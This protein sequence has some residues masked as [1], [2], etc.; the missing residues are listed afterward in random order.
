[1]SDQIN[2]QN[3]TQLHAR[4]CTAT[5]NNNGR[6]ILQRPLNYKVVA[7]NIRSADVLIHNH[8]SNNDNS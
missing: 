8:Q 3:S 5:V 4:R 1:M 7:Q 6:F 2:L